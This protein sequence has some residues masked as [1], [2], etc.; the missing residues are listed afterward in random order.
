MDDILIDENYDDMKEDF[1]K[2]M[3]RRQTLYGA[4]SLGVGAGLFY[5]LFAVIQLPQQ[6]ALY[7]AI[8][9]VIPVAAIGFVRI[10]DMTI[11]EFARRYRRTKK[12]KG[13]FYQ[14]EEQ[15]GREGEQKGAIQ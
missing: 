11:L 4:L 8:A 12:G 10:Y 9:G 13:L 15:P 5:F 3:T 7:G 2:G 1:F 6:F 14:P